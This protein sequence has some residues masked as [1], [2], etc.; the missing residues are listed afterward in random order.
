MR[1]IKERKWLSDLEIERMKRNVN[2]TESSCLPTRNEEQIRGEEIS[3]YND[4]Q[5]QSDV[6][7]T[8]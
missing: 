1:Q 8:D 4:D 7:G 5:T 6:L 2:S 3:N